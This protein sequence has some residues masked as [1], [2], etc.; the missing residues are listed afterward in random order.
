MS[1][2]KYNKALSLTRTN[3]NNGH[4]LMETL[5]GTPATFVNTTYNIFVVGGDMGMG[6]FDD[7]ASAVRPNSRGNGYGVVMISLLLVL[8]AT[9]CWF[10]M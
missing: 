10:F 4:G 6:W 8:L 3:S 1:S 7:S 5:A 2:T 9:G